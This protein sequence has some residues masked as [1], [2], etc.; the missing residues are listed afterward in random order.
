LP[1]QAWK[2]RK[3]KRE[4][5]KDRRTEGEGRRGKGGQEG[6]SELN[7]EKTN[8]RQKEGESGRLTERG[9]KRKG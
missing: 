5:R 1:G 7:F 4:R 9:N 6:E 3:G 8:G 2:E